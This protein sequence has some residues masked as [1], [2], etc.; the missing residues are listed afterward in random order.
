VRQF[1]V[2]R[3]RRNVGGLEKSLKM[4]ALLQRAELHRVVVQHA[5]GIP[6]FEN[7]AA[8]VVI[9]DE[10]TV[11]VGAADHH[12]CGVDARSRVAFLGF[13]GENPDE[14]SM[15]LEL[16]HDRF[17]EAPFL[18]PHVVTGVPDAR[19][20]VVEKQ[21]DENPV[22]IHPREPLLPLIEDAVVD[23]LRRIGVD[24]WILREVLPCVAAVRA[25]DLH[26]DAVAAVAR[27]LVDERQLIAVACAVGA[28]RAAIEKTLGIAGAANEDVSAT[29]ALQPL[30]MR[31]IDDDLAGQRLRARHGGNPGCATKRQEGAAEQGDERFHGDRFERSCCSRTT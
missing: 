4:T 1:V 27:E 2:R 3:H 7:R 13:L 30:R 6:R 12:G 14:I 10:M 19:G 18:R 15:V 11:A 28:P 26:V 16:A 21:I 17:E 8:V 20:V 5:G 24:E 9:A 31:G 22:L 25:R 23:A 29:V